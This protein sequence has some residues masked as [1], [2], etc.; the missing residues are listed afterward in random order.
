MD[1]A[2]LWFSGFVAVVTTAAVLVK[3]P[4]KPEM[5]FLMPLAPWS[6]A[7]T[8][9]ATQQLMPA[10]LACCSLYSIPPQSSISRPDSTTSQGSPE[11]EP[12]SAESNLHWSSERFAGGNSLRATEALNS[13]NGLSSLGDIQLNDLWRMW[14]LGCDSGSEQRQL[15]L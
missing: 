8:H 2:K 7:A 13:E 5:L 10:W 11:G 6:R 3:G 9:H 1:L 4:A 14:D 15:E 12:N